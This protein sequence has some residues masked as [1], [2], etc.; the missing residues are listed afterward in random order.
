MRDR[1][2]LLVANRTAAGAH[3][4]DALLTREVEGPCRVTLLVPAVPPRK[5]WTWDE[6]DVKEQ[7]RR[8]MAAAVTELR[9][10]GI[11]VRGVVGDFSPM[12]SIRDAIE[13]YRYDEIIISTLPAR[14]SRW[15][16][17]DLPTRVAREFQIPVTHMVVDAETDDWDR[18]H[19]DPQPESEGRYPATEAVGPAGGD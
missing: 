6:M 7:A 16:R 3:L 8:R 1:R 17:Q 5:A 12:E 14:I 18:G 15:L 4:R 11:D 10:C 9:C 19:V 2:I 13:R